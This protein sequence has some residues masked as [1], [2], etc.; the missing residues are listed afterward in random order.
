MAVEQGT[1]VNH[2]NDYR[3]GEILKSSL[4]FYLIAGW[5]LIIGAC[6]SSII[7]DDFG[8]P[9]GFTEVTGTVRTSTGT[10]VAQIEVSFSRCRQPSPFGVAPMAITNAEGAYQ[11]RG[12]LAPVGTFRSDF[13]ADTLVVT[14]EVFV[15]RPPTTRDLAMAL[16][17]V[18][19]RFFGLEARVV[20]LRLDLTLP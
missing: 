18:Q 11:A 13:N 9:A 16:D 6:E 4:W 10:P 17:T 8:P 3:R 15:G 19:L 12:H 20:P 1:T 2:L 7:L 5:S 14:C